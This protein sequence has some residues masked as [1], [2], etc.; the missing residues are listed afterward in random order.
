MK[1]ERDNQLHF[2]PLVDEKGYHYGER[3]EGYIQ[4]GSVAGNLMNKQTQ[5]A[6]YCIDGVVAGYP[7]LGDG[8]RFSG[9]PANY[10]SLGI[11]PDDIDEFMR[12][13]HA[14][15]A[16]DSGLVKDDEGLVYPLSQADKEVLKRYLDGFGA[17]DTEWA[18]NPEISADRL[19]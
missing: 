9:N 18:K 17:F 4:F 13:F 1:F 6:S 8:L 14:Y 5:Y 3:P 11:H 7:K 10:H 2:A 12:R 19:Y 16:Y 15:R